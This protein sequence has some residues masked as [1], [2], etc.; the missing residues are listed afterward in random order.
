MTTFHVPAAGDQ[1]AGAAAAHPGVETATSRDGT[2]IA[3][4]RSG[5]GP[6]VILVGGAFQH[7]AF[8]PGTAELATLLAGHFTVVHYDRRGRGASGDTA[9]Y[10]VERELDD[11]AAL[12]EQA[13]GPA[14]LYGSSSGANLALTAAQRG[15]SVGKLALW[16]PNF[17]VDDSR[18]PLPDDYVA[19][20]EAHI[21]A[22]RRGDAVAYFLTTAAGLPEPFVAPMRATPMWPGMEA[23]AHTL[24][25]D[26]RIVDS[27][28]LPA[29][30]LSPGA[31]TLVMAGGQTPW[32]TAGAQALAKT[33]P[34]ATFRL[35]DG[36]GHAVAADAVGPVLVEFFGT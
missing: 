11:L 21:A 7:R 35:L 5:D 19:Q 36:Q 30:A 13:G 4:D 8:D 28:R 2:T 10:A 9:P 12:I 3:F 17:L 27:F 18:P 1:P 20:L 14:F 22:G 26:A 16:E 6:V 33:L 34:H 23:V 24:P 32:M 29:D 25:Y 31:P 15:L